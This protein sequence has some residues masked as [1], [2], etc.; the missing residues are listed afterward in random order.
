MTEPHSRGETFIDPT[1]YANQ[2]HWQ[3]VAANLRVEA[4]V[5]AT[6]R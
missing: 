3:A 4:P 1:T 6:F 2:Q 5:V